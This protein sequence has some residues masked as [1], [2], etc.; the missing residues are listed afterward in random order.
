MLKIKVKE[1]I[2]YIQQKFDPIISPEAEQ[3]L[4]EYYKYCRAKDIHG[5]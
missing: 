2:R 3:V 5:T 4:Q 1:Y